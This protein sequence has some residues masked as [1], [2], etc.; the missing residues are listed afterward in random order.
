[1]RLELVVASHAKGMASYGKL[2]G[3]TLARARP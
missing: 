1:M 3:W 2:C